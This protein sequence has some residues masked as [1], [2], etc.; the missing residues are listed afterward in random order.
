VPLWPVCSL[1]ILIHTHCRCPGADDVRYQHPAY[2]EYHEDDERRDDGDEPEGDGD[3]RPKTATLPVFPLGTFTYEAGVSSRTKSVEV[4]QVG[5]FE[6]LS[7]VGILIDGKCVICKNSSQRCIHMSHYLKRRGIALRCESD[8]G[9]FNDL[10]PF[11]SS[12]GAQ[13][14]RGCCPHSFTA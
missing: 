2:W 4:C 5:L 14:R 10:L 6:D 3:G 7:R 9:G 12:A 13:Q 1:A 11:R 8:V